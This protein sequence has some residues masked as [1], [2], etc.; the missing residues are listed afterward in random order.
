MFGRLLG[1][2]LVLGKC[3]GLRCTVLSCAVAQ[4]QRCPHPPPPIARTPQV[5]EALDA[6]AHVPKHPLSTLFT[7]VYAEVPWHL[8]E[9]VRGPR[10]VCW[11]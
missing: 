6:A 1:P 11:F 9:Q 8:K 4:A 2:A 5:M 10:G 7:D 3:V